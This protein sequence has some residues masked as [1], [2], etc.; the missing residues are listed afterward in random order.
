MTLEEASEDVHKESVNSCAV[1]LSLGSAQGAICDAS[2]RDVLQPHSVSD[3]L[4]GCIHLPSCARQ[5]LSCSTVQGRGLDLIKSNIFSGSK[6][7]LVN[8]L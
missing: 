4:T 2:F 3:C 1:L 5:L 8:L 6:G 7:I